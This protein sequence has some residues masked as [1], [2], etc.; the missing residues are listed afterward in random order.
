MMI[1]STLH[2]V[3]GVAPPSLSCLRCC[4]LAS[5]R[6]ILLAENSLS[7][8]FVRLPLSIP[9]TT[10]VQYSMTLSDV[11][12]DYNVQVLRSTYVY[13]I[14]FGYCFRSRSDSDV[15]ARCSGPALRSGALAIKNGLVK[16]S[17]RSGQPFIDRLDARARRAG[18]TGRNSEA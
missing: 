2:E 3:T 15:G 17:C 11:R 5:F 7:S 1:E 8:L 14:I 9:H 4:L 18:L 6:K 12:S 16:T 13:R 10:Y